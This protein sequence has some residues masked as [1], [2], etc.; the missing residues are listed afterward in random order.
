MARRRRGK[1]TRYRFPF[2]FY[3]ANMK[4]SNYSD[5]T[6][7]PSQH[8]RNY[9]AKH[10]KVAGAGF[11][12]DLKRDYKQGLTKH[13]KRDFDPFFIDRKKLIFKS[14]NHKI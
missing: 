8:P 11:H 10:A 3:G 7:L 5:T 6:L 14:A 12:R 4:K 2:F 1:P 9:V 13:K